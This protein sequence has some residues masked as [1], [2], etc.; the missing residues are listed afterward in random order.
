MSAKQAPLKQENPCIFAAASAAKAAAGLIWQTMHG[1]SAVKGH[2]DA[3]SYK[4][5]Q[6]A[7]TRGFSASRQVG[8]PST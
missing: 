5:L 7:Q 8:A 2:L 1:L 3:L 4:R 6:T